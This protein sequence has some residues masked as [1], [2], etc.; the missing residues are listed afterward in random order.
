MVKALRVTMIIY[1]AI[2]ILFGLMYILIPNQIENWFNV[3]PIVGYGNYILTLLCAQ[4]IVAGIFIIMAARDPI[5]YL[6]W[7]KFAIAWGLLVAV[8]VAYAMIRDYV[9]FSQLGMSLIIH[10]VFAVL[11]LI[12]YPWRASQLAEQISEQTPTS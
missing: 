4:F 7:V 5:R 10:A 11:L 2:D 8:V 3:T 6:S 9:T 12:F 1:A